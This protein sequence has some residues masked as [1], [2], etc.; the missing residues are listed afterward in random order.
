[1]GSRKRNLEAEAGERTRSG[2]IIRFKYPPQYLVPPQFYPQQQIGEFRG[3]H[4]GRGSHK[5]KGKNARG[6]QTQQ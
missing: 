1:M 6:A 4:R 3:G 2:A 5:G